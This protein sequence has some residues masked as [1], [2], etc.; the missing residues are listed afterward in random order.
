MEESEEDDTELNNEVSILM[1]ESG[2]EFTDLNESLSS[3]DRSL[4]SKKQKKMITHRVRNILTSNASRN[5][6]NEKIKNKATKNFNSNMSA[7]G[8]L[9]KSVE[10]DK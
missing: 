1:N 8:E 2:E 7:L 3:L 9:I 5:N 6:E 10:T 4:Y